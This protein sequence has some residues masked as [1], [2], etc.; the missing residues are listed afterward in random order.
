[1]LCKYCFYVNI[2]QVLKILREIFFNFLKILNF[3]LAFFEFSP[4]Y[5]RFWDGLSST[6]KYFQS[7]MLKS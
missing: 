3:S 4:R 6:D 2:C 7:L 5:V 1:M